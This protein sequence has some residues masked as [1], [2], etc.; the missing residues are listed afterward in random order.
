MPFVRVYVF[1]LLLGRCLRPGLL[2]A[3]FARLLLRNE[4]N[5]T[6]PYRVYVLALGVVAEFGAQNYQYTTKVDARLNV[7][8]TTEPAFLQNRCYAFA[9]LF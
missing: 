6:Y 2:R 8:L 3:R 9:L 1:E 5:P 4:L 7:Q